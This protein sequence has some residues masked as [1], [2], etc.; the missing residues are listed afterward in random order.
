MRDTN[1]LKIFYSLIFAIFIYFSLA[2]KAFAVTFSATGTNHTGTYQT[3]TVPTT[4]TYTIEA[5][6]AEG[7]NYASSGFAN[8]GKGHM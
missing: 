3:Y 8:G 7:G 6:G 2:S 4:G 1:N 5:W